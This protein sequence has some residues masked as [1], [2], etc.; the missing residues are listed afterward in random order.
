MYVKGIQD[1]ASETILVPL[2]S[3]MLSWVKNNIYLI[4]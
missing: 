2:S 3:Y 4:I 1:H